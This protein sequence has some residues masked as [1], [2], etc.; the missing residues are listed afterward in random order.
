[1][2]CAEKYSF[3]ETEEL[4]GTGWIFADQLAKKLN[5]PYNSLMWY[6]C[7]YKIE[8]TNIK[9]DGYRR[10][11]VKKDDIEEII[12]IVKEVQQRRE[13]KYKTPQEKAE[14]KKRTLE[15]LKKEHPLVTDERFFELSYF[16]K[17]ELF[18]D[19]DDI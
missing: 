19:D 13:S 4:K 10:L 8:H 5:F 3:D 12:K 2:T 17:L 11:A 18:Q 16:P 7:R 15:Q 9:R 1:M 6:V 14:E